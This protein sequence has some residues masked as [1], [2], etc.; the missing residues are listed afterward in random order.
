MFLLFVIFIE[1]I[2]KED[3]WES[4]KDILFY[5]IMN[6]V[7]NMK[8]IFIL[9]PDTSKSLINCI[10]TMMQGKRYELRY[11]KDLDDARKIALSYQ[12]E[13][14]V[15]RLYAIGGDGFV[16][17]VVNGMVGSFHELVVIPQG[18]GNDFARSIYK[19]LD[20]I[21]ILKSH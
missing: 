3:S 17:K 21:K 19:N 4:V 13:K 7:I 14:E 6:K 9:K 10:V 12:D 11:T 18:T 20:A 16:H 5:V 1:R 2:R 8:H 15:C